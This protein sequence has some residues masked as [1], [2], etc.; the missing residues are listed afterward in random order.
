[1]SLLVSTGSQSGKGFYYWRTGCVWIQVAGITG[2]SHFICLTCWDGFSLL[3][4]LASNHDLPI[5]TS[6][7]PGIYSC[8]LPYPACLLTSLANFLPRLVSNPD[9]YLLNSWDY[10]ITAVICLFIFYFIKTHKIC[11]TGWF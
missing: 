7:V 8:V 10:N 5:S 3:P 11:C 1:V 6:C 9:L 2:M 4:E